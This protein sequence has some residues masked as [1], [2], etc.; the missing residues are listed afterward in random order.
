[1]LCK[2]NS[3]VEEIKI[4]NEQIF[5]EFMKRRFPDNHDK[6]YTEEWHDRFMSGH[7]ENWMDSKSLEVYEHV[8]EEYKLFKQGGTGNRRL[9]EEAYGEYLGWL[10][11]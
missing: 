4:M 8:K 7:P 1:M 9:R 3:Q 5:K 11:F 6:S 10:D 2:K